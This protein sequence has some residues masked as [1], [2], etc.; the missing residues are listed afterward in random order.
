M[1][2]VIFCVA[3]TAQRLDA[4]GVM[5]RLRRPSV[6]FDLHRLEALPGPEVPS[7]S[8]IPRSGVRSL[9]KA[10]AAGKH[11]ARAGGIVVLGQDVGVLERAVAAGV[12]AGGGS[13]ALMPDGVVS[14]STIIETVRAKSIKSLADRAA[15]AVNGLAGVRGR[16]GGTIPD[17]VLSWGRGWAGVW[18]DAGVPDA[19]VAVTGCARF[20]APVPAAIGNNL[21]VCSQPLWLPSYGPRAA[22]TEWYGFLASDAL[23]V[24]EVRIRLHPWERDET[25]RTGLP[26][27]VLERVSDR[28]LAEDLAWAGVVA[29]PPTTVL[30]EAVASGRPAVLLSSHASVSAVSRTIPCFSDGRIPLLGTRGAA[31]DEILAAAESARGELDGLAGDYLGP[32]GSAAAACAGVLDSW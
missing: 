21:L 11:L 5:A 22:A 28:P 18:R 8:H 16:F 1:N 15:V 32:L 6:L 13:L 2:A 9:A 7:G 12:R 20:D 19:A 10:R 17:L 26:A 24:D 30:L 31:V 14:R 3:T 29:G 25:A 4:L 23:A 27:H